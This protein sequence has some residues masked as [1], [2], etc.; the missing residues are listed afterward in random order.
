MLDF[1]QLP[2]EINSGLMYSGPG[3]GPLLAAAAVRGRRQSAHLV[4]GDDAVAFQVARLGAIGVYGSVAGH[5]VD[6]HPRPG[7]VVCIL[8][9]GSSRAVGL[10]TGAVQS[11]A[12]G[13]RGQRVG[14][15]LIQRPGI[16]RAYLLGELG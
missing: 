5:Y 8:V 9:A 12:L 16:R 14:A 13:Q 6:D 15:A 2:P 1:A 7:P 3:A 10:S 11:A 4:G